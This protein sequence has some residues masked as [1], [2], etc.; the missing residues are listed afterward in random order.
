MSDVTGPVSSLPGSVHPVPQGQKCDEH[1]DRPAVVRVQGETD[2]FGSEMDDLCAECAAKRRRER[3]DTTGTCDWCKA[4]NVRLRDRRDYDEGLTGP[5]YRVCAPC[6][7]KQE[8]AL[9]AELALY[10][11][12][13][14]DD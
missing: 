10:D 13:A 8:K 12:P 6:V 3:M 1:P 7:D 11:D 9:A 4:R 2:S 5:V 14:W